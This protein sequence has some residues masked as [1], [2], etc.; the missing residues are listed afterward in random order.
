MSSFFLKLEVSPGS[1]LDKCATEAIDIANRTQINVTF[2]FNGIECMACPGDNPA[3]LI[4]E[5]ARLMALGK[6]GLIARGKQ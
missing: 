5:T 4:N 2:K 3:L 6:P 1:L